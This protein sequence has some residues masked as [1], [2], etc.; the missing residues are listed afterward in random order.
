M[1]ATPAVLGMCGGCGGTLFFLA[2][3]PRNGWGYPERPPARASRAESAQSCCGSDQRTPHRG[4]VTDHTV[5]I[6][7]VRSV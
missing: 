1:N 7:L 5:R 6:G 4:A 2:G 3:V